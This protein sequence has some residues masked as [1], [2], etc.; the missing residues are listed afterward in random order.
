M[1]KEIVYQAN[2]N[3]IQVLHDR[4]GV[5]LFVD[6]VVEYQ[7]YP[8]GPL[9]P[10][11]KGICRIKYDHENMGLESVT[12]D[13][14]KVPTELDLTRDDKG[15]QVIRSIYTNVHPRYWYEE[16]VRKVK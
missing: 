7:L 14:F 3:M 13:G 16:F 2:P 12:V 11:I 1:C 4:D 9:K 8:G 5:Q 10:S 15:R 6:D